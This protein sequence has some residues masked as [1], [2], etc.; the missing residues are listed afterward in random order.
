MRS[1]WV[2]S[3]VLLSMAFVSCVRSGDL[4]DEG[5]PAQ[6][7]TA[8]STGEPSSTPPSVQLQTV[9]PTVEPLPSPLPKQ[10]KTAVPTVE[11]L[12]T[13]PPLPRVSIEYDGRTYYGRQG[14]SCWPVSVNSSLCADRAGWIAFDRA[15]SLVVKRGDGVSVILESYESRLGVVVV[16]VFTVESTV[17]VVMRGEEVYSTVAGEGMALNLPPDVYYLSAFYKS[18]LGDVSYGFKLEIVE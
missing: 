2:A 9:T 13:P 15:P 16:Q 12:A 17:P 1:L 14:S 5:M 10:P 7:T 6:Q 3:A 18:R 4:R 8:A 11:P